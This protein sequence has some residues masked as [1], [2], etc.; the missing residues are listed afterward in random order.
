M[1]L[2]W[3][4]TR[5]A[6]TCKI[7]CHPHFHASAENVSFSLRL[8]LRLLSLLL[9][10]LS[11]LI[12]DTAVSLCSVLHVSCAWGVGIPAS[13]G[14]QNVCRKVGNVPPLFVLP[15]FPSPSGTPVT[16][17]WSRLK[18]SHSSLMLC[19]FVLF[20]FAFFSCFFLFFFCV[21]YFGE[22]LLCWLQVR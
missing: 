2:H 16:H 12:F 7:W 8:L 21:F 19:S 22:P 1:W 4:L 18:W 3:L 20:C 13:L 17:M 15:N 10:A 14:C 9:W 6:V 5:I 11:N